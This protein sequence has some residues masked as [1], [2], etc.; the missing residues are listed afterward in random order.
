MDLDAGNLA[1]VVDTAFA[2]VAGQRG[3]LFQEH[4]A[5]LAMERTSHVADGLRC[6]P[7]HRVGRVVCVLYRSLG[8]WEV[9]PDAGILQR[10]DDLAAR[11]LGFDVGDGEFVAMC[12]VVEDRRA[13]RKEF[14][15]DDGVDGLVSAL[16]LAPVAFHNV[17]R[18]CPC[19]V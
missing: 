7:E 14:V 9:Y 2:L 11:F 17:G 1:R 13:V 3:G 12:R 18:L 4:R 19:G 16:V 5:Y 10:A 15:P 6:Y 8:H